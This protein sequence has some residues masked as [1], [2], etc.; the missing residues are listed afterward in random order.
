MGKHIEQMSTIDI[1]CDNGADK[2]PTPHDKS[3]ANDKYGSGVT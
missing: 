3:V 2:I 1:Y